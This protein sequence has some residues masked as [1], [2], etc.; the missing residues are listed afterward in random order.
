LGAT[1]PTGA[2]GFSKVPA[3]YSGINPPPGSLGEAGDLY[4]QDA[5]TQLIIYSKTNSGWFVSGS[6]T[7][8]VGATGVGIPENAEFN[9]LYV[10]VNGRIKAVDLLI[11]P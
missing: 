9:K 2:T 11:V 4:F 10:C 7:I 8:P 5:I 1:G 3:T 6:L